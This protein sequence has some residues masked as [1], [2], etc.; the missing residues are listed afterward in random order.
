LLNFHGRHTILEAD[1]AAARYQSESAFVVEL[2]G[3]ADGQLNPASRPKD[4]ARGK[5]NSRTRHI[6]GLTLT[7]F[8]SATFV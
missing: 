7:G 5:E 8:V 3:P 2:S 1:D 6:Q 4:L